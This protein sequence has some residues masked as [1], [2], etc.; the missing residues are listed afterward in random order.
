MFSR[1]QN[2]KGQFM[3]LVGVG[4]VLS[5][6]AIR[7]FSHDYKKDNTS[8]FGKF[9]EASTQ[10]AYRTKNPFLQAYSQLTK[11]KNYLTQ[12]S[13]E[14]NDDYVKTC[15][16]T[17]W[18]CIHFVVYLTLGY[19]FPLF[20]REIIVG[21]TAFEIYEYFSCNCHDVTDI[22]WNCLGV[23]VGYHLRKI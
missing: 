8:L 21:A 14:V 17:S 13:K 1:I 3:C 10:C 2:N 16:T 6:I 9:A 5:L 12:E 22:F 11:T 23:F 7:T 19:A 4:V 15:F 18:H 20:W